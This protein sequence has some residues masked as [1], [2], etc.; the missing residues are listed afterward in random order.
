MPAGAFC[1][2]K[3]DFVVL[4]DRVKRFCMSIKG[5]TGQ[6]RILRFV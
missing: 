1:C 3:K 5:L 4:N 2:V 6:G